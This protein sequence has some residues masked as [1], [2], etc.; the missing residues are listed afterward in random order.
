[1]GN[2]FEEIYSFLRLDII[3]ELTSYLS[4]FDIEYLILCD[5]S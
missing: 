1:M 5:V 2:S 3:I 4:Y